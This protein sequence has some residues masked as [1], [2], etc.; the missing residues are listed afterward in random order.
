MD[1]VESKARMVKP[2]AASPQCPLQPGQD[3]V[4]TLSLRCQTITPVWGIEPRAWLRED[5]DTLLGIHR[6][7]LRIA[8]GKTEALHVRTLLGCFRMER[9][10]RRT[11]HEDLFDEV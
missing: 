8:Q 1:G 3:G 10:E 4:L 2:E 6:D 9:L 7:I 5:I 11:Y